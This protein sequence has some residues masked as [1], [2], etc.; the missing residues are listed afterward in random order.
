MFNRVNPQLSKAVAILRRWP[1]GTCSLEANS[2]RRI[3][4][5]KHAVSHGF[6]ARTQLVLNLWRYEDLIA[7]F[8]R[9]TEHGQLLSC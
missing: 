1:F 2:N 7:T 8:I 4:G 9:S 5:R 6:L 3:N